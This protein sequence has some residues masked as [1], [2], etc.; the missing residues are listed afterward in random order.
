MMVELA[1][2]HPLPLPL[3]QWLADRAGKPLPDPFKPPAERAGDDAEK[4]R[5][6][7]EKLSA[8]ARDASSR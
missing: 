8:A 5:A 7:G 2:D 4:K 1:L 3:A 6:A